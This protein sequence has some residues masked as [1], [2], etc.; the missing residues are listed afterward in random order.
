MADDVKAARE[1][2]REIKADA[3][4]PPRNESEKE[5]RR[6]QAGPQNGAA[7]SLAQFI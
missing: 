4:N 1:G 2:G 6:Q 3:E 5:G 7:N